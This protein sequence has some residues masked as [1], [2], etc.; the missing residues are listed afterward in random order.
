MTIR[1]LLIANRGEIACRILAT[2]RRLGI[3]TVLA[4]SEVDRDAVPARL[5]DRVIVIGASPAGESYLNVGAVIAAARS[6]DVD[7]I[8]PG[9]GF[10]AE[11]PELARRSIEADVIFV[12]PTAAQLAGLGDKVRARQLAALAGLPLVPGRSVADATEAAGFAG[13]FGYPVLLKAT[14]GG[15]GKGMT[16]IDAGSRLAE[17]FSL[18][19]NEA[20][21]AFGDDRLYVE[22]YIRNGRHVEV[23]VLGDGTDVVHFGDRDC[24]IQRRY[25]KLV[26]EAPAPD[27][28][29]ALRDR[30]RDAAVRFARHCSYRG[31]GTVEFLADTDARAFYFLEMNARIQVEHPVTEAVTG[32]DLV[33]EQIAVA[34]GRALGIRQDDIILAG[35]AIE[36]RINAEDPSRGFLPSPGRLTRAVFPAGFGLRV[37]THVETGVD[38]PPHYDS[39]VAKI[40]ARGRDRRESLAAMR[41][42]LDL[43]RIDGI[44]TNLA[45]QRGILADARFAAGGVGIRW[46]ESYL[47]EGLGHG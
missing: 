5:A 27:L 20:R 24:S 41:R 40:I 35:H 38:V 37:D 8:H 11:N 22:R 46:L 12:G 30:I 33:A 47:A 21:A 43:C 25:Q 42:A 32:Y 1:S 23:Q 19:Q 45:L 9:Y 17:A 34:G 6:A 14:A 18:A 39:L 13:E 44:T 15:G 7:A 28:D 31:L 29:D 26:E 3:E 10:L 36:C 16:R 2:C 4:A